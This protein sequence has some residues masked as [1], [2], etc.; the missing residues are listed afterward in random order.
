[1]AQ[2]HEGHG[3][4][5]QQMTRKHYLTLLLNVLISG[6]VMYFVM[7]A[8]IWSGAGFVQNINFAYMAILMATPMGVLML[9]MMGPKC[10]DRRLNF[11]LHAFFVILF[12]AAFWATRA[13]ALVGDSQFVRSMIP[14]HSGA[15]LMCNRA[16]LRDVE[17]RD[18][19]F[20]PNGIVESQTREIEQMKA[21]Q[22]RL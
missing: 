4:M 3:E 6:V 5:G 20:G 14:H 22:Q 11:A 9:I 21:I 19:C 7:F 16:S 18:L 13:Q 8:M 10:P 17:I 2:R 12:L 15:L 1:M